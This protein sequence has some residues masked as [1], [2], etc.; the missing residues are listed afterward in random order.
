[1][2]N[3]DNTPIQGGP[4]NAAVTN[5]PPGAAALGE[6]IPVIQ[7]IPQV[8]EVIPAPSLT[9]IMQAI[10]AMQENMVTQVSAEITACTADLQSDLS[11]K[12][13]PLQDFHNQ[14]QGA[15]RALSGHTD[16]SGNAGVPTMGG[17]QCSYSCRN[18]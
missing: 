2:T 4:L 12:L 6:E 7:D 16:L 9:S 3:P 10:K 13:K 11:N 1:M 15:A 17:G 8:D 14:I 18:P 5:P